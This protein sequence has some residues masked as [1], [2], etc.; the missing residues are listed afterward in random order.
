MK[1]ALDLVADL[2]VD[3]L[4]LLGIVVLATIFLL[5]IVKTCV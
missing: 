3:R 1:L 2:L 4:H 5:G